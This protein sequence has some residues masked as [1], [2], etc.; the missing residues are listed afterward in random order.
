VE[1]QPAPEEKAPAQPEYPVEN[2]DP[3]VKKDGYQKLQQ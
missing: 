3:P 2:M 1:V